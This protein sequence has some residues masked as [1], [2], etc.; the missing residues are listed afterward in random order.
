MAISRVIKA[1]NNLSKAFSDID[2]DF[3]R[4]GTKEYGEKI[5]AR[6]LDG[7]DGGYDIEG[8]TFKGLEDSTLNIRKYKGISGDRILNARDG[9]IQGFLRGEN[10]IETGKVQVKL[11]NPPHEYMTLQNEGFIT[12]GFLPGKTVP[13]R[14][15]YGIPKT[16]REGG[17]QYELF[18]N[19]TIKEINKKIADAINE[20]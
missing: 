18:L 13:A 14:K 7:L 4:E 3:F 8:K 12:G 19:K 15:W 11:N 2:D 16:Y 20:S 9:A 5:Q 6:L 17:T 1:L 10:L